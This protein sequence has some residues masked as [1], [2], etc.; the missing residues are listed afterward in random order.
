MIDTKTTGL[1]SD[2]PLVGTMP[3]PLPIRYLDTES[4][5]YREYGWC[6]NAVPTVREI[7]NHLRREVDRFG[8]L[9][10]PW[11][12]S[13]A[14]TNIFLLACAVSDT[15]DDYLLGSGVDFSRAAKIIPAGRHAGRVANKL[16]TALRSRRLKSLE[17]WR[18]EWE[19]VV[20]E[21]LQWYLRLQQDEGADRFAPTLVAKLTSLLN[22]KLP[23]KLNNRRSRIP[24][25]F[26]S[27]DLTHFD[28]LRLGSKFIEAF[29]ER[30]RDILVVGLRTAGSYLAPLLRAYLK[31]NGYEKVDFVTLRPKKGIAPW[32]KLRL[33]RCAAS[34]GLA[35]IV[36][37]PIG[38]GGTLAK[39][40][41]IVRQ[42]GVAPTDVVAL[43]PIHPT[44]REW[45][46][47]YESLVLSTIRVLTLEPEEWYKHAL[48][49][50]EVVKDRLKE[51]FRSRGYRGVSVVV[52]ATT[53][54]LTREFQLSSDE[55]FHTRLKRVYEIELQNDSGERETRYVLAKSV[56][57]GWLS[58]HAF[59]VARELAPFVP[60]VLGL[61]D[62]ILYTE[63][64]CSS[65]A[66]ATVDPGRSQ[67]VETAASYVAARVRH[68]GLGQ[69][70]SPDLSREIRHAG[71]ERLTTLLSKAYGWS[72]AMALKRTRIRE[73][74]SRCPCPY[75]TLIDGRMRTGEWIRYA[76]SFRKADFE[77]HGMGKHQLCVT[78]PAY[79]LADLILHWGLSADEERVLV[80]R[81]ATETGDE[82]ISGRLFLYKV[83][84]GTHSIDRAL[85][86][87]ASARLVHR[88]QEFHR[89]YVEARAF[90]TLQTMRFS[91]A[92][93]T[94]PRAIRWGSPLVVLDIDG[95]LDKQI[96]GY[97]STTASGILAFSLLHS[98]GRP[99]ALNTARTVGQ[100][101][102]YCDAYACVGGVAEY[103][104]YVWDAVA[105]RERILVSDE[106][107]NQLKHLR[108]HL[109][110]T[111]GVFVNDDYQ[112]S[113]QAYVYEKGVTVPLPGALIRNLMAEL[114]TDRLGFHQTYTDTTV[115][116]KETDKGRGLA[117]LLQLAGKG[118]LE[119]VAVGDSEPDLPMFRVAS[120]SFAPA[121]ISCRTTATLLQCRISDK[122][123]QAGLLQIVRSLLHTDGDRC[124]QCE[125]G[126]KAGQDG[127]FFRLLQV[128]DQSRM[129]R[130]VQTFLDP[131]ALPA[132][133]ERSRN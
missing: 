66:P 108:Q 117:A 15:V 70:P 55:G 3:E 125:I 17:K 99:V 84:A 100:M 11:H 42:A 41:G 32:E 112:Y 76:D 82:G 106:S 86:G 69:D 1:V 129:K 65:E 114:K 37:E 23:V 119:T 9:G 38:T 92:L 57:W 73:E 131:M 51:Y 110:Q 45:N 49:E 118:E 123:Y 31:S 62:G 54:R 34:K 120:H 91:A 7:I 2:S 33:A 122:A 81:Y 40:V 13:E 95:V 116:A 4:V 64:L 53:E 87:L 109:R 90:L 47:S 80:A 89:L 98:H 77:H 102:E 128:A 14:A 71:F 48:L 6:L 101:K 85:T 93:V 74:L 29:P 58:Y 61:R 26:R 56:G 16:R 72:I 103:G 124:E 24:A 27:Q 83:L 20:D 19:S 46:R 111:P 10:Q 5:F 63:W 50:G 96:F 127:L 21:F 130:L 8:S 126:M 88:H 94:K 36:D 113:I 60:P 68:M 25:A 39:A 35:A 43:F 18:N 67:F 121:N 105:K 52:S 115:I 44:G 28:V 30:R 75:P 97:P 78:D 104:S 22:T 79:D 133:V 107:M 59:V 132:V 12:R